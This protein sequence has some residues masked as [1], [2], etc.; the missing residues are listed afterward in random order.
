MNLLMNG[1]NLFI[2][3]PPDTS[4]RPAPTNGVSSEIFD[5]VGTGLKGSLK[6]LPS[7]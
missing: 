6:L 3:Q 1:N 7:L 5:S 4:V 2:K